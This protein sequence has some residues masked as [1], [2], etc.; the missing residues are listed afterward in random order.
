MKSLR[1]FLV[2]SFVAALPVAAEPYAD[3]GVMG[4]DTPISQFAEGMKIPEASEVPIPL[5]PGGVFIS[6]SGEFACTM[7][8]RTRHTIEDVC[9]FYESELL[10]Q[11]E[12]ERVEELDEALEPEPSCA[13]YR[14]GDNDQGVGVWV[15]ENDSP[16]YINNGSTIIYLS[17]HSPS[18]KSCGS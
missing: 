1:V 9:G 14:D 12:Y 15:Y 6:V 4:S 2:L 13:I 11:P 8:I 3:W 10:S 16:V 7:V 5:A 18:E 17:Y